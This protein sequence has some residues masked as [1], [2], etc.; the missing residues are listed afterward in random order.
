MPT[1]STKRTETNGISIRWL[2]RGYPSHLRRALY[3]KI[4]SRIRRNKRE[5]YLMEKESFDSYL[6]REEARKAG[7]KDWLR[8]ETRQKPCK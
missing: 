8:D 6:A 1:V 7:E 5:S 4:A 3:K 2:L